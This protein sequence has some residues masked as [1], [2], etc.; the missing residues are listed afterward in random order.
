MTVTLTWNIDDLKRALGPAVDAGVSEMA[1]V[2]AD[3]A[4]RSM[5]RDHG[6]VPSAPGMSPNSQSGHLRN[7]IVY[8]TPGR[9]GTP[10]RAAVGSNAPYAR[11]LEQGGTIFPKSVKYLP[12]PINK[13]AKKMLNATSDRGAGGVG[14]QSSLRRF[15]LQLIVKD[16]KA[17]LLEKTATGKIKKNGAAFVLKKSVRI[18]PRPYLVPALTTARADMEKAFVDAASSVLRRAAI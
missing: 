15:K 13:A 17:M 2:L 14:P 18:K 6:G 1:L 4:A 8:V 3:A 12:V 11:I 10:G 5:G 7:S 16:G 9:L